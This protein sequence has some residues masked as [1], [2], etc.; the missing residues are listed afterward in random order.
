VGIL[1]HT[2]EEISVDVDSTTYN[3][4]GTTMTTTSQVSYPADRRQRYIFSETIKIRNRGAD[5]VPATGGAA[6]TGP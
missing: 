4:V 5:L 6:A 3:V 1:F 2:P